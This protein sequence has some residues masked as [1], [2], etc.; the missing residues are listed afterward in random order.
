MHTAI[1]DYDRGNLFSIRKALEYCGVDVGFASS[2]E[3]VASVGRLILPG[4]GAF[5]DA[6]AELS[7]RKLIEPILDHAVSGRP[8]LGIC[9]GMQLLFEESKEFGVHRG[10]GLIQG[11]IREIPKKGDNN[12]R[13]KVP[14][15][16]WSP[17]QVPVT[18]RAWNGTLLEGIRQDATC[19]FVHSFSAVP[20]ED[21]V[22]LA[23]SD[24]DGYR[25]SAAVQRE[26][27]CGCQFH[28]EKSGETGLQILRNFFA[29]N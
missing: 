11:S 5:G 4:V 7:R 29:V 28:P 20:V 18:G 26:N 24:F 2:P 10:L 23:D 9:L 15:I 25:I 3:Q 19:Y 27:I 1:I 13:R 16:G 14:H 6:M 12:I 22:R 8:I 21:D 17:L